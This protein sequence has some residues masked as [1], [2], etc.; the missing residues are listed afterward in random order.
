[1][2]FAVN[3]TCPSMRMYSVL[4][5]VPVTDMR[6]RSFALFLSLSLS[7]SLSIVRL[8]SHTHAVM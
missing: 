2:G 6:T 7:L 5:R 3:R 4:T 1:M 8:F